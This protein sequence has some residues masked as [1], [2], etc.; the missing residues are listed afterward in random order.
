MITLDLDLNYD[1]VKFENTGFDIRQYVTLTDYLDFIA[2]CD[3]EDEL[4]SKL[5]E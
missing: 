2:A 4:Y 5:Y 3:L 1:K